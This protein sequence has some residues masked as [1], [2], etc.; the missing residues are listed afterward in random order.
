MVGAE[1]HFKNEKSRASFL[2]SGR[3]MRS[4]F[5]P[6]FSLGYDMKVSRVFAFKAGYTYL[7]HSPLN[8]GIGLIVEARPFQFFVMSDNIFAPFNIYGSNFLNFQF[9]FNLI[10]PKRENEN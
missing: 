4:Y 8:I 1:Y 5:E 3:F 9:G 6:S 2:F 7:Q 10:W